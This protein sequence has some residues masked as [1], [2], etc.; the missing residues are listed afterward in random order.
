MLYVCIYNS[1][2][3][4]TLL[5][6]QPQQLGWG[7]AHQQTSVSLSPLD[8]VS[9]ITMCVSSSLIPR[10]FLLEAGAFVRQSAP[11]IVQDAGDGP[12]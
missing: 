9:G 11:F 7:T 3:V 8:S 12:M 1:V 2:Y 10:P 6:Y 4:L 5:R